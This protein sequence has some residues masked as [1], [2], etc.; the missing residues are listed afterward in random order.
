LAAS[1]IIP[2]ASKFDEVT[3]ETV[4]VPPAASDC[5]EIF[6]AYSPAPLWQNHTGDKEIRSQNLKPAS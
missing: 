6:L 1:G 2:Q 3:V 5:S 4:R